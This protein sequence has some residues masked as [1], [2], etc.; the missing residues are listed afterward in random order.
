MSLTESE[1]KKRFKN[2]KLI[3]S[4]IDGTL[5]NHQNEISELT[6]RLVK[7]LKEKN[8]LFSLA[9]QRVH[10]SI[11][12]LANQLDIKIPFISLNGSLIQDSKGDVILNK[13]VIDKKYVLKAIKLANENYI[14]IALCYNDKIIYTEDNSVLKD[15]MSRLGTT[16]SMVDSYDNYTD[17][18]FEIILSGND[19]KIMKKIQSK[20][21]PPFGLHLK[22]K[23]YRSQNFQGVYNIEIL[24]K[25]VNKKTGLKLLS[26]YLNMKKNEIMVFGDWYND[27]DLFQ[28]GGTNIA[29]QNA[30]DE[31]KDMAD[32]VCDKSND[33]DGI[34]EFLKMFYDNI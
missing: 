1:L 7:K 25:G 26:K 12:P 2:I 29:L 19:R 28:F 20:M 24:R 17:N 8:I 32:F 4:D 34:G 9:S 5:V 6:V 3:V 16:Y 15:F 30:V 22:V 14:K 23:Y 33:E 10:S 18:V 11:V 13:S 21:T 27:R 31:L